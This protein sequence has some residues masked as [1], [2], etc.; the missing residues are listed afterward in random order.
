[1]DLVYPAF[2]RSCGESISG[3]QALCETCRDAV[4]SLQ[5]PFCDTCGEAFDGAI[6]ATFSCG[7]CRQ[8]KFHFEFARPGV[9]R[10]KRAMEL[11]QELKYARQL[12]LAGEVAR[13]AQR[14]FQDP[15]LAPALEGKWCLVPV[16]LHRRRLRWR[17]FN[18]AKEIAL[19]LGKSLGLPVRGLLKRI[20][21]TVTQTRLNRR[22][23]Q[24]NLKGAFQARGDLAGMPGV[25]LIDDV[26]TTGSTV[27][28]CSRVLR[29]A[30]VQKVVVVTAMRG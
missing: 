26:L 19:P 25:V 7:N 3:G 21:P 15:R 9:P 28:E 2:C 20:R 29:G 24:Q 30:G 12:H 4:P 5:R 1:L 27:N 6:D 16:P 17:Q 13:L 18:Q 14:A 11:I 22:Q 10:S 23:R 8:Q